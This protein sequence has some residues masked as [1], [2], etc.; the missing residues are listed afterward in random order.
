MAKV[1]KNGGERG[2]EDPTA[3]VWPEWQPFD[4]TPSK[5][6]ARMVVAL[7][8]G[9]QSSWDIEFPQLK[10]VVSLQNNDARKSPKRD[11]I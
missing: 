1:V 3:N 5:R 7:D 9:S 11:I 4:T 10:K 8:I 2:T 6:I